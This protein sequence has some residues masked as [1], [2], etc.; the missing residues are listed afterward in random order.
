MFGSSTPREAFQP[1]VLKQPG[2][3]T[4]INIKWLDSRY[5]LMRNS[6][7]LL[8][9]NK[10][11]GNELKKDIQ[12]ATGNDKLLEQLEEKLRKVLLSQTYA[13]RKMTSLLFPA[14]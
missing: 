6:I 3:R 9:K 14:L 12:E 8:S 7:Q 13:K 2:C 10:Y 11:Y 4:Y 1:Q 5:L